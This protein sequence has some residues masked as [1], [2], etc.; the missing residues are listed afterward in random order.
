M[1]ALISAAK[2]ALQ[3]A[4]TTVRSSD[5]YVTEDLGLIRASGGYPAVGIKDGG[6]D[7][8]TEAGNQ[9][10]DTLTLKVGIY[11]KLHKPEAAIMGDDSASEPGLLDLALAV[12]GA[13]DSTLGG[14][15]D[16]AE[17]VSV[18]ESRLMFDETRSLQTL[19]V[20]M[21]FYRWQ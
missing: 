4:L 6:T 15:V 20:T 13:L 18:S 10:G 9:R 21:R 12:I 3:T 8:A 11:V 7:F 1:K 2:T 16:L 5:V 17:P 14:A 19:D